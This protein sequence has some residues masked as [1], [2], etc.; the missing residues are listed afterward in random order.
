MQ[1]TATITSKRQLTIP[2]GI[3]KKA[4]LREK[5][6]V[7]VREERGILRIE[8]AVRA[9]ERLAASVPVPKR[10]R[11]MQPEE[12]IRTSKEEYWKSKR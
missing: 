4:G 11:G 12:I 6:K 2:A 3:F 9:V 8:P 5:Q 10:F 1:G 7:I